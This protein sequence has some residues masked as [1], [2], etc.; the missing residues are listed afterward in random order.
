MKILPRPAWR[1]F[2]IVFAA[3]LAWA[4][5]TGQEWEDF[6]ITY[7]ASK[8]LAE[9]KGLTYNEGQRVHSFT[10]PLG[11]LLP[12]ASY[13]LTGRSS[14]RAALWIFRVMS[15]TA[16]GGAA[17][18][19]W[20][21]LRRLYP[22]VAPAAV[23]V[24]LVTADSKTICFATS[25]METAFVL[26]F[27]S[28]VLWAMFCRPARL[29]LHLGLAWAGLMWSRPDSCVYIAALA[30]GFLCFAPG[31]GKFLPARW[32]LLRQLL[33]AGAI[34][35]MLYL[36]WVV[37]AWSY[38][39]TP[40]PHTITAKGLFNEIS[41]RRLTTSL[42][43]FPEAIFKGQATL[44]ATFMPYYGGPPTWPVF[45]GATSS[46]LALIPLGLFL[47]PF[48]R[49]EARLASFVYATGHFYLTAVVG[50]PV[51]WYIPHITVLGLVALAVG[52]G[53]LLN[54]AASWRRDPVKS[55]AGRWLAGSLH[56]LALAVV[57]GTISLTIVMGR[58]AYLEMTIIEKGIR[59]GI[60]LWLRGVAKSAQETVYLEPLGFIGFY[61]GLRMLDYPGLC[62]PEVVAARRRALSRSYPYC[63][64]EI[65]LSLRPDWLV[66]RPFELKEI[67][68]HDPLVLN[69]LYD[70]VKTFDATRSI[71][72]AQWVPIRGYL[73]YNG[74][75]EVY[76][77]NSPSPKRVRSYVPILVPIRPEDLLS[78]ESPLPVEASG[79][80]I[81]SHAP[82]RLVAA[83]PESS[84]ILL[85][86][87]GIYDGAYAKPPPGGTDGAEFLVEHV[88]PN[89]RRTVLLQ[90]YLDPSA[91]AADRGL[92]GFD[93]DLP[94]PQTGQIVFT[95]NPGPNN[96]HDYDWSYWHDLR[97]G[98]PPNNSP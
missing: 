44:K 2:L 32:P 50:F 17:V 30:A 11:V 79:I 91:N 66:L 22:A 9:G 93:L 6:Y 81:K 49:W 4:A 54:L 88:A 74:I 84:R 36:P 86:G 41:A 89:G 82:S 77:L 3:G 24:A 70:H 34:C 83:V 58:Q 56:A 72:E 18:L 5:T 64:S 23:L 8:N 10:S 45:V 90:R 55:P 16:L 43:H 38:Y 31:D 97:F 59:S 51:P 29:S 37:W 47:L 85:G 60:G 35:T 80:G 53:Q 27:L 61:S 63:W 71:K 26:L 48:V 21:T 25:G 87:F 94:S 20:R 7:R 12:A 98:L 62:A 42:L 76:H 67:N 40:I 46:C 75:F 15:L 14:D 1:V 96:N 73:E 95:V 28:W 78:K 68:N 39:G 57:L 13:V 65:I 69:D 52:F 92:Q 19:L 33:L